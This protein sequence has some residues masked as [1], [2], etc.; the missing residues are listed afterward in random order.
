MSYAVT[1]HAEEVDCKIPLKDLGSLVKDFCHVEIGDK[2]V[3][4]LLQ[5]EEDAP[6]IHGKIVGDEIVLNAK[7]YGTFKNSSDG[8]LADLLV[9]YKGSGIITEDGEGGN[10]T[11]VT[12]WVHGVQKKGRVVFDE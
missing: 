4:L 1:M 9:T 3:S 11:T 10:D 6:H 7:Q 2:R 5:W 8:G 12:K